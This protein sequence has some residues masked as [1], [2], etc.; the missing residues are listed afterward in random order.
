[1]LRKLCGTFGR[2]PGSYLINEDFKMQETPFATRGYTDLWKQV[3]SGR[4]VAI[5]VVRFTPDNGRS[6]MTKVTTSSVH[7]LLG[8]RGILTVALDVL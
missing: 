4:E 8:F 1:M 7:N 6:K 5:K 3:W 2:L